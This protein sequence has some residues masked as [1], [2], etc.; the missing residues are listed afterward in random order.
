MKSLGK[1]GFINFNIGLLNKV[2]IGLLII[3][4]LF[5]L[6]RV[7]VP[8]AQTSSQALCSA[9]VPLGGLFGGASPITIL[10]IMAALLIAIIGGLL[11][12][13]K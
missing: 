7:L 5:E 3:T 11:G 13:G 4:I 8:Q 10:L 12:K 2:V 6:A 1:R 9:G